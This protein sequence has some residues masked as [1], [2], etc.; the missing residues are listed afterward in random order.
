MSL[1]ADIGGSNSR[2]ALADPDGRVDRVL[3]ID[4][5]SVPDLESGIAHDLAQISKWVS[6]CPRAATLAIAGPTDGEEI[7]LTNRPWRSR[8]SHLMQRFGFTQLR[9]LND[10]EAVAWAV[11]GLAASELKPLGKPLPPTDG[12]KVVLGPGTGL[13]VAALFPAAGGWQVIASEGGHVSFGPQEPDEFPLFER[14][15]R[16]HGSLGAE[17]M[18]CGAGLARLQQ[19]LDPHA[20]PRDSKAIVT[21]ALAREPLALATVQLFQRLLGRFAGDMALIFKALGGVYITGGVACGLAALLDEERFR[22]AFE[23]HPP[24][25]PLLARIPTWLIT[26]PEPGLIGCASVAR[27]LSMIPK[28]V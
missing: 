12:V 28:S 17:A 3:A 22:T 9:V 2:F 8:R 5:D 16:A 20:A 14:L 15:L 24:Y 21:A 23:A 7:A 10:F 13:G 11:P 27:S 18:L 1:I 4:N 25:Q 6:T 19:A 26:C